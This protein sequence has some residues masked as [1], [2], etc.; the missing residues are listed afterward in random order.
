MIRSARNVRHSPCSIASVSTTSMNPRRR[1]R[2]VSDIMS[3][4]GVKMKSA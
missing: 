1:A 4:C 3:Q 2:V